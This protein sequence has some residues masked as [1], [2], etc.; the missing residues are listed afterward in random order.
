M[1]K[2]FGRYYFIGGDGLGHSTNTSGHDFLNHSVR[3]RNGVGCHTSEV[4]THAYKI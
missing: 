1:K 2:L 4:N 3:G